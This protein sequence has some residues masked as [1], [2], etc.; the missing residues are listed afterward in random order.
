MDLCTLHTAPAERDTGRLTVGPY[1]ES[2]DQADPLRTPNDATSGN[3]QVPRCL[4]NSPP[5]NYNPMRKKNFA[6]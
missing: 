3:Q 2:A 4:A 1:K 6:K 5:Q